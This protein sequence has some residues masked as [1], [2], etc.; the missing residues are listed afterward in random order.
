MRNKIK[1]SKLAIG[2]VISCKIRP[3]QSCLIN[4]ILKTKKHHPT[5]GR[6][7]KMQ[8]NVKYDFQAEYSA[9]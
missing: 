6:L 7:Q 8:R 5:K 3:F 2:R 1:D 9:K 4:L